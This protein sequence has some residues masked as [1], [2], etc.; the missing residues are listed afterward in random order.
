MGQNWKDLIGP[1]PTPI[2]VLNPSGPGR[3]AGAGGLAYQRMFEWVSYPE[4][5]PTEQY[6]E[7]RDDPESPLLERTVP[8]WTPRSIGFRAKVLVNPLGGEVRVATNKWIT[9]LQTFEGEEEFFQAVA[10]RVVAWDYVIVDAEGSK[11]PVEPP[12]TGGWERFYDLP[13]DVLIWL[14]QEIRSAHL[15]KATTPGGKPAGR[16]A[17]PPDR[18]PREQNPLDPA[19]DPLES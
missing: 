4:E 10:D 12:A 2:A 14:G 19:L 7:D 17:S 8:W 1:Q 15:P 16:P 18:T 9:Y 6:R 13:N 3:P 11:R 5:P